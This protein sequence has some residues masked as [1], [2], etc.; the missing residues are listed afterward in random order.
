MGESISRPQKK[1][2][3]HFPA[4]N[5]EITCIQKKITANYGQSHS[6]TEGSAA[7]DLATDKPLALSLMDTGTDMTLVAQKS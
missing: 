4:V 5:Q 1:N 6:A 2:M 3:S 7:L